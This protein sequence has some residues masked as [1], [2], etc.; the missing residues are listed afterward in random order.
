MVGQP[1]PKLAW[2]GLGGAQPGRSANYQQSLFSVPAPGLPW[3]PKVNYNFGSHK[4]T[5]NPSSTGL[6][7]EGM[8]YHMLDGPDVSPGS[9]P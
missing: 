8:C 2:K 4:D 7:L 3:S 1:T 9:A 6:N 5:L